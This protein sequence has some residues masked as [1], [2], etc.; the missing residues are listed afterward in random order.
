VTAKYVKVTAKSFGA[1]PQW[2][3]GRGEPTFIFI[4]EI[5]VK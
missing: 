2:H 4:D 5:E 3:E 1:M